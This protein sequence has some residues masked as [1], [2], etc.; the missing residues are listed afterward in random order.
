MARGTNGFNLKVPIRASSIV[1]PRIAYAEP[2]GERV[3]RLLFETARAMR[4]KKE[5]HSSS[6]LSNNEHVGEKEGTGCT[7]VGATR[8]VCS[9]DLQRGCSVTLETCRSRWVP[10]RLLCEPSGK[11]RARWLDLDSGLAL[12]RD[13]NGGPLDRVGTDGLLDLLVHGGFRDPRKLDSD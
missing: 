13:Q 6:K 10:N 12:R 8:F 2:G 9:S 1:S 3:K 4:K 11:V 7:M 5:K